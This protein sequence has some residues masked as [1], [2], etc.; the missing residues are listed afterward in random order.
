MR[1]I[2]ALQNQPAHRSLRSRLGAAYSVRSDSPSYSLLLRIYH[3]HVAHPALTRRMRPFRGAGKML[4][5]RV[6]YLLGALLLMNSAAFSQRTAPPRYD[7]SSIKPS[8]D[9]DP[10]T[11]HIERD[12]TLYATGITIRR[13][14]MTGY[15]VQGFRLIGGPGWVAARRWDV[16][17][18]PSRPASGNEI[19]DML[20]ALLEDRFQ[21]KVHSETRNRPL[22]D[23]TVAPGGSKLRRVE[24]SNVKQDIRIGNG[25][26]RFTRATVA[27]FA[28]QLSYAL[29]RPVIDKTG[30]SGEFNFALEWTPTPGENDGPTTSGLPPGT[31]EPASTPDGPSIFTAIEEQLGLRLKSGRGPVAVVVIDSA[32]MPAAN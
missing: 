6:T 27:T 31:P 3:F 24:D 30:I 16:Q 14:M 29:A 17:A 10:Y 2:P 13:L 22:Y 26:I 23:L 21:L 5:M 20:R 25:S 28:S 7:V 11:F 19:P 18:K 8:P 9:S 4:H 32:Q 12:G 1:L 15:N